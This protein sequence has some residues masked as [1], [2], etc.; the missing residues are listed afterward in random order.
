MPEGPEV[1]IASDYFNQ[2]FDN[3]HRLSFMLLTDYYI[4]KYSKLFTIVNQK[5][6]HNQKSFTIGKNIFLRLKNNLLFN[7][8]LGMTGGWSVDSVKHCHFYITDGVKKIYFKDVRKFAK[9]KIVSSEEFKLKYNSFL[10]VLSP[11]HSLDYHFNYLK[12]KISKK[13]ICKL[14]MDQSCFPGVGNYIKSEVLYGLK[15]HPEQDWSLLTDEM[16]RRVILHSK[17]IMEKSYKEGGAELKDFHN[18][19]FKSKFQLKA[20]GNKSKNIISILTSDNRKTWYDP[21]VQKMI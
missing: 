1:K 21:D 11:Y 17:S 5:L 14:L 20:Y 18:P 12:E 8:H 16:K 3:N 13:S 9:M 2:Y 15:I 4:N 7:I 19:F 10:D 6:M